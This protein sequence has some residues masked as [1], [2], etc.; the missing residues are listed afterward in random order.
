MMP[1]HN[2]KTNIPTRSVLAASNHRLVATVLQESY[3]S[4]TEILEACISLSVSRR[5][6]AFPSS[7]LRVSH[8]FRWLCVVGVFVPKYMVS[9]IGSDQE[10]SSDQESATMM[11][12]LDKSKAVKLR[13]LPR[14]FVGTNYGRFRFVRRI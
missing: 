3:R 9:V 8:T 14:P 4:K 5:S 11:E 13:C 12:S 1:P 2:A 10:V 6:L 7:R